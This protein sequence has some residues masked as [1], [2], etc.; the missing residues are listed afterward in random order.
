MLAL[1]PRQRDVLSLVADGLSAEEV[2]RKLYISRKTVK[3]HTWAIRR[4]L[5]AKTISQ[6]VAVAIRAGLIE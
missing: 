1:T 6:A 2:G 5:R 3:L 4:E